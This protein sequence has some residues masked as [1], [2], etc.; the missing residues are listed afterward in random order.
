MAKAEA[1]L[2][3][4]DVEDYLSYTYRCEQSVETRYIGPGRGSPKRQKRRICRVRYQITEVI[5]DETELSS[6]FCY[7]GFRLYATN[8]PELDLSLNEAFLL[9][10]A[11]PRIERHFHLFKDAPV[12]IQ[13]LYLR[14]DEQIKGLVRL[15]SLC[16]RLLTL[17]E[18]V[19]RRHLQQ[20]GITLAGLYEGNPKRK[21][22]SPTAV[23]ILRA[24]RGI[25]RVQNKSSPKT[26][27][28]SDLQRQIL[29]ALSISEEIYQTNQLSWLKNLGQKCK[30]IARQIAHNLERVLNQ[31]KTQRQN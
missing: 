25:N 24:F 26:T 20:H 1:I 13:P 14:N 3:K 10:R 5:Q 29:A 15:L 8:Q 27:P 4:Y 9:Y 2:T 31:D 16:V 22:A 19:T 6:A 21:T 23:R 7:M 30:R 28:L 11:A 12:G 18:I 17:I